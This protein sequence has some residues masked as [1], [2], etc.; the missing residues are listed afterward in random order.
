MMMKTFAAAVIAG[1]LLTGSL[2]PVRAN[3]S[4]AMC[5]MHMDA[6]KKADKLGLVLGLDAKQKSQV[7]DLLEAKKK[8]IEP[9]AEQFKSASKQA[10]DE[11]EASL[12]KILTPAQAKKFDEWKAMK[13]D[14]KD[15]KK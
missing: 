4:C 7:E 15:E 6:D 1:G 8:K 10:G 12:K 2:T 11:F 9:A 3:E 14:M 5:S 13:K